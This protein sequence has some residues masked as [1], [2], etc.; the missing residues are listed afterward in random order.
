MVPKGF[1]SVGLVTNGAIASWPL[2]SASLLSL[3]C[4]RGTRR[5]GDRRASRGHGDSSL[6]YYRWCEVVGDVGVDD[7][8]V[9]VVLVQLL[10]EVVGTAR[11]PSAFE[12]G[13]SSVGGSTNGA[14]P[15]SISPPAPPKRLKWLAST[16]NLEPRA[17]ASLGVRDA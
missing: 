12:A 1:G 6:R 17:R 5:D 13:R 16:A 14:R 10:R 15:T 9:V 7:D 8:V 11:F 2:C 3:L 4:R